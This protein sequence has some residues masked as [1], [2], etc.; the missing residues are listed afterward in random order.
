MHRLGFKRSALR[1]AFTL[2]ELLVVIAIV[3]LL[4]ALLLPALGAARRAGRKA[5]CMSNLRQL[6]IGYGTYAIDFRDTI[7]TF[8]WKPG[9]KESDFADLRPPGGP[10]GFGGGQGDIDAARFQATDIVRRLTGRTDLIPPGDNWTPFQL[11]SHLVMNSYLAQRLPEKMMV[12]PEDRVRLQRQNDLASGASVAVG[13][14][15]A[16]RLPYASSYLLVSAAY[17][18]DGPAEFSTTAGPGPDHYTCFPGQLP[19]GKRRLTDVVFPGQ[20]V[21]VMDLIARHASKP[22]FYAYDDAVQPLLFFDSSV[23]ELRSDRTNPGADPNSPL[24]PAP[25]YVNY[26]PQ[27]GEGEPPTR[28]G[29]PAESVLAR[30]QWTR[31]GLKGIDTGGV[32]SKP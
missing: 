24:D 1:R 5:V 30:Y 10:F 11:Y 23:R 17:S 19:L 13:A 25:L 8:S 4:V 26:A 28:S 21:F 16:W 2:I 7:A 20:K 22:S 32:E 14:D 9:N 3:A 15:P 27:I 31:G 6:G 12:C 18:S 29:A